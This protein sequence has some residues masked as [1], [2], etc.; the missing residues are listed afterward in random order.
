MKMKL[1][2]DKSNAIIL[3]YPL[4]FSIA[5]LFHGDRIVDFRLVQI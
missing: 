4:K 1:D 2:I 3:S 5:L